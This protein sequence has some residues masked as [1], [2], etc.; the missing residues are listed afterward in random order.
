MSGFDE[1]SIPGFDELPEPIRTNLRNRIA[2]M[3]APAR[4]KLLRD[5]VPKIERMLKLLGGNAAH[6]NVAAAKGAGVKD[7]IS[8][9]R[10]GEPRASESGDAGRMRQDTVR[11]TKDA[12][13]TREVDMSE[14][15][16]TVSPGDSGSQRGWV[17]G[18]AAA[19]IGAVWYAMQG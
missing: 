2:K 5:G 14:R 6:G 18:G 3:P 15:T 12:A 16:P 10:S 4:E 8:A 13:R 9:L 19:L 1:N 11:S 7:L 17:V